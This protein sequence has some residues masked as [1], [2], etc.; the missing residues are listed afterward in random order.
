MVSGCEPVVLASNPNCDN[1]DD[2]CD[3]T[4]AFALEETTSGFGTTAF[5]RK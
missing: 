5:G 3:V 4:S 2:L 1:S